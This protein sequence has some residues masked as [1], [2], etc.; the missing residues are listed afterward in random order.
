M[1]KVP[2]E[3]VTNPMF[4][5]LAAL[6]AIRAGA[7]RQFHP[8]TR[9]ADIPVLLDTET[10][11]IFLQRAETSTRYYEAEKT[12]DRDQGETITTFADGST[13][14]TRPL[15]DDRRRVEQVKEMT[16]GRAV[17]DFGCGYGGFLHLNQGHAGY[18]G[19]VELRADCR[20]L[21]QADAPSIRIEKRI[22]DFDRLFEF[23]SLF[24]V[25]E[26][27]P[28]QTAVLSDIHRQL[29][30]GGKLFIE[31]PHA[32]DFLIRRITLP[33][34]RN[35]TFWSEH[36]VLHTPASLTAVLNAAGFSNF[37]ITG[38]QRYGYTNHLGWITQRKPGGQNYLAD[39][40]DHEFNDAYEAY[41]SKLGATDTLVAVAVKED[42]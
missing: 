15:D 7:V 10:G 4:H 1:P 9:D 8:R 16:R 3:A 26:H 36:L 19:G 24:H 38:Y 32:G 5:E 29:A 23:V 12:A 17:C 30:P 28:T 33:A 27:I 2:A 6:G 42:T 41:L 39:L 35:F 21:L 25:L 40:H 18:L 13:V 20:Q 14:R 22:E 37:E 11:V 31:V 34:F